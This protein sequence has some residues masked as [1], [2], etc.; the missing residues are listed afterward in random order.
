MQTHSTV[1]Q[2]HQER[3]TW[4]VYAII[5]FAKSS[6]VHGNGERT[7]LWS[8]GIYLLPVHVETLHKTQPNQIKLASFLPSLPVCI[9]KILVR[10][11]EFLPSCPNFNIRW[12]LIK[13]SSSC[14]TGTNDCD[15]KATRYSKLTYSL[16]AKHE[17]N[18]MH[19]DRSS[20]FV[21]H[22]AVL[23]NENENPLRNT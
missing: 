7:C 14:G 11:D 18:L 13:S 6:I 16:A 23:Q 20:L 2:I 15:G 3:T 10:K 19:H 12:N 22:S 8:N 5:H 21:L 9:T 17:R 4:K 1:R